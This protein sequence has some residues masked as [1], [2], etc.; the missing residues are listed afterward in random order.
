VFTSEAVTQGV[1]V[2]VVSRYDP[3]R[4]NPHQ[5]QWFFLYTITIINEGL[6]TVQLISRHWI[7]TNANGKVEE[8]KGPGVV[9]EQPVLA[10][11]QSFEYTSGCPLTTLFGTMHG[12]YQMITAKGERF[13][14]Q[15]A[16][17]TLSE[18]HA[19]H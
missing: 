18:P 7:I 13:D 17:F 15:I 10:P 14:A 16:P 9:G 11:G 5:N 8:V 4:S 12:T 3:S 2:K 1:R 19:L 6:V